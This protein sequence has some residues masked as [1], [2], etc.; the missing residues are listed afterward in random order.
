MCYDLM[1]STIGCWQ[2]GVEGR[3]LITNVTFKHQHQTAKLSVHNLKNGGFVVLMVTCPE[4]VCFGLE[5][6]YYLLKIDAQGK[7]LGHVVVE[8]KSN[9]NAKNGDILAKVIEN[10]KGQYCAVRLCKS[11]VHETG[12]LET[13][14]DCYSDHEFSQ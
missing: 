3:K 8:V 10:E 1:N 9:C 14:V 5:D 6:H 2:M 4:M 13:L 12:Q 11:H 7:L